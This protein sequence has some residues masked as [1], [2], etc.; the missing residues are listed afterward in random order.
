MNAF[1]ELA[2]FFRTFPG[3]GPR[4][5]K[6][7]VYYLLTRDRAALD[8][9]TK[10]VGELKNEIRICNSC[11]RFFSD[12]NPVSLCTICS[13]THRDRGSLMIIARD[14]D[15][16]AV[17]KSGVWSG[18][19]FVL[20]GSVPLLEKAPESRI[21]SRE[22]LT[23]LQKEKSTIKEIVL[24]MNFTPEGENTADHI[25]ELLQPI[26]EE[27]GARVSTL[28]RGLSTGTELEYSDKETL[29]NA[30]QNRH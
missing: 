12:K 5:A 13:D 23:R 20:G 22:L 29:K 4:Q 7:F 21:R 6:R 28:G 15:L 18:Q 3:I 2:E 30:L 1:N 16:E 24:G 11:Y 25:R 27:T 14:T 9:F 17:E 26:V 10:L 19:Y 8:R